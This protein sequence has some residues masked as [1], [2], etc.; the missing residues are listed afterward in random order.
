MTSI[1]FEGGPV[2]TFWLDQSA[3]NGQTQVFAAAAWQKLLVVFFFWYSPVQLLFEQS[4]HHVIQMQGQMSIPFENQSKPSEMDHQA[5]LKENCSLADCKI[6]CAHLL[7]ICVWP[8][9]PDTNMQFFA[10]QL[11]RQ[12]F[13]AA[14]NLRL[15]NQPRLLWKRF[16]ALICSYFGAVRLLPIM[17]TATYSLVVGSRKENDSLQ[18]VMQ[19]TGANRRNVNCKLYII[20]NEHDSV[21]FSSWIAHLQKENRLLI[22]PAGQP[23]V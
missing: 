19:L 23:L 2:K 1:E 10:L 4:T 8:D 21:Q 9:D 3:C 15:V 12:L 5:P 18:T 11:K 6:L 20:A 22:H 14:L 13:W 16:A 7:S 17:T